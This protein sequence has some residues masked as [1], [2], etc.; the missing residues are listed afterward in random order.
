MRLSL[1]ALCALACTAVLAPA[2]A[3]TLIDNVDGLAIDAQGRADRFAAVLIGDDGRIEQIFRRGEKRPS[4]VDFLLDGKGKVLMPGLVDSHI[5]LIELGLSTLMLDLAPAKSLAEAQG[6]I[7]AYAA[8]HP[9]KPWILGRGWDAQ[10]WGLGRLPTAAD[11]DSVVG[12]R[13]VWLIDVDGEAG[14]ANSAALNAAG[15]TASARNPVGGRIERVGATTRPAGVLSGTAADRVTATI[16]APRPEDRDAALAAAQ[17]MLI[18]RGITAVADMGTTIEDWQS[19]RRAG[20]SGSLRLRVMAYAD[21]ID[22]MQ[23]IAGPGPTPWLYDDRLRLNGV[24]LKADG[25]LSSRGAALKQPYADEPASTGLPRL[26]DAQLRNM[27]SR[28]AMDG[29]QVAVRAS[30]DGGAGAVLGAVAELTQTY[31]GDRRWRLEGAGV[32]DPAD[33]PAFGKSGMIASMLPGRFGRERALAEA[34][35]GPARLAGVQAWK[36][37]SQGDSPPAFGSGAPTGIPT[38]F[39]D[40]AAAITRQGSDGQ[41]FGGWQPQERLGR[42]AAIGAYTLQGAKAG[43]GEGRFGR[44]ARGEWAD[45]ILVDR[46]PTLAPP[47]EL[48]ATNVL[49]V[50]IGGKLVW[51]QGGADSR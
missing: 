40:I 43:F 26:N 28:A 45:F 30:G 19:L 6:R 24:F 11:L 36:S 20:D 51:S 31:K 2:R 8:A 3:D 44:I 34:R 50:W 15:I 1:A 47:A 5:D 38:P 37:L 16:P 13:P 17:Q 18:E 32:I 39:A 46:D 10:A 12:D 35:L 21:G 7:A 22:A 49:K 48:R 29:F 14:W 42:E 27:M 23:L 41:P 9:D 4:K 25:G 33:L